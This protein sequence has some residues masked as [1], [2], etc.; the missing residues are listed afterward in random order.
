MGK[1]F[2]AGYDPALDLSNASRR[3]QLYSVGAREEEEGHIL[4]DEQAAVDSI[5][6]GEEQ[7]NY[8]LIIGPKVRTGEVSLL[9]RWGGEG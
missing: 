9:S 8:F 6:R 3:R 1:A 4:R 2:E 5:I 7:G